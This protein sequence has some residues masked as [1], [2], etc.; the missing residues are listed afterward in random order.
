MVQAA[1]NRRRDHPSVF[2]EAMTGGHGLLPLGQ[3]IGNPGPQAGMSSAL[4]SFDPGV[5]MKNG[6]PDSSHVTVLEC[7]GACRVAR[8]SYLP[9][10]PTEPDLWASHPALRDIGVGALKRVFRRRHDCPQLFQ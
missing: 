7:S 1:Q 3:R 5:L 4:A 8:G 10:A 6:P 2:G 9:P